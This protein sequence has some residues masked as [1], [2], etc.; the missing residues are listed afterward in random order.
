MKRYIQAGI[1]G[2]IS[3]LL[4][5]ISDIFF[6]SIDKM[7]DDTDSKVE[8]VKEE[9]D[10]K[11]HMTIKTGG[12]HKIKATFTP[13][14]ND[15]KRYDVVFE[16]DKGDKHKVTDVHIDNNAQLNKIY[17]DLCDKWYGESL[18]ETV[19]ESTDC[20]K[21]T[22]RK[23]QSNSNYQIHL[24]N[25][26]CSTVDQVIPTAEALQDLMSSDQFI[27]EIP[28][29]DTTFEIIPEENSVLYTESD[30]CE[31]CNCFMMIACYA[32]HLIDDI[33]TAIWSCTAVTDDLCGIL[34]D[35]NW[36]LSMQLDKLSSLSKEVYDETLD[37]S[38][39]S[40][41]G[42]CHVN[43]PGMDMLYVI[44]NDFDEYLASIELFYPNMPHDIQTLIDTWIRQVKEMKS[45][46]KSL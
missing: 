20:S 16:S 45:T 44:D 29:T 37:S 4:K 5:N 9:S 1:I 24:V 46:M 31:S 18:E 35:F 33:Q 2:D 22:L 32:K 30:K 19:Q 8:E 39:L 34:R 21:V 38:Q 14:G 15:K 13:I 43:S 26:Y 27:A 6:K 17:T 3:N 40:C 36:N 12:N 10:G 41:A 11:I 42:R 25:V 23:V 28:S 7:I